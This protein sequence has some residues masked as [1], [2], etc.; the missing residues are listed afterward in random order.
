MKGFLVA[1][2][3][4]WALACLGL[5]IRLHRRLM[6]AGGPI[7]KMDQFLQVLGGPWLR[8]AVGA[9]ILVWFVRDPRAA[10][11]MT[12]GVGLHEVVAL[13]VA[14]AFRLFATATLWAEFRAVEEYRLSRLDLRA[15]LIWEAAFWVHTALNA[16]PIL[17]GS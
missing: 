15:S 9:V 17:I 1:L 8:R 2:G 12:Q 16:V 5:R 10:V 7:P 4:L 11:R 13:V 6:V 14:G 3:A